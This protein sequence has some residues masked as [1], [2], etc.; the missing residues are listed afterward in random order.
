MFLVSRNPALAHVGGKQKR[1]RA[2]LEV[3]AAPL[4]PAQGRGLACKAA[5]D[6]FR[7]Q[8]SITAPI[9]KVDWSGIFW[10]K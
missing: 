6:D 9:T 7:T 5:A 4:V 2:F 8:F 10:R 1:G 3:E